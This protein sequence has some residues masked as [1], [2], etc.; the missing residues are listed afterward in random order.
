MKNLDHGTEYIWSKEKF[1]TRF[2][3]M[4]ELYRHH[5]MEINGEEEDGRE[6]RITDVT[7]KSSLKINQFKLFI[8]V[9]S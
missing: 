8:R 1:F 6:I 3:F 7:K 2:D 9:G 4:R 5:Q